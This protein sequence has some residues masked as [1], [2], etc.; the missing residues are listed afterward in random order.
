M[1]LTPTSKILLGVGFTWL[2]ATVFCKLSILWMYICIFTVKPFRY[3]AYVLMFI[4]AGYGISFICVF[5]T[6]C[7]T[8][9]FMWNP[10]PGGSCKDIAIEEIL[11]VS[12]NMV[13]DT[14]IV[15]LPMPVL[16]GLQLATRKKIAISGIFSL[17]LL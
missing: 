15:L 9:D 7:T 11:S 16:W 10:V 14:A 17:G 2:F 5:F 4:V 3:A 12:V 1:I 6:N 13:I 8:L